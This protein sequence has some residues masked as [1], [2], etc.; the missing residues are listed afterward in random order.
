MKIYVCIYST[1]RVFFIEYKLTVCIVGYT[2]MRRRKQVAILYYS[3]CTY[4]H[5]EFNWKKS[6]SHC[7]LILKQDYRPYLERS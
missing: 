5:T 7:Q 3:A 4:Q 6:S 1:L 2:K